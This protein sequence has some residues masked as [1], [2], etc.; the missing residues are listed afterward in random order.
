MN[1]KQTEITLL[2]NEFWWGGCVSDGIHMPFRDKTFQRSLNPNRTQNQAS[3]LL[4]S[5]CGRFVWSD[6]PFNFT[7]EDSILK[8][9]N[10]KGDIHL[11]EGYG[12]LREAYRAAQALYFPPKGGSPEELLFRAPQYNT[13][14][15]L[16]YDQ[17]EDKI[18]EYAQ[19]ILAHGMPPGVLMIDD[20]WQEDY[21]V[22]N[23]HPGRFK[24]PKGMV[25]RLHEMG[26]KV[27]LWTCPF[28]S[29]DSATY[30]ELLQKGLL[31]RNDDGTPAIRP[32][33]NGY[34][35]VLDFTNDQAVSWFYEQNERLVKEYGVDGFKLDAGDPQ[36][37]REGD[38]CSKRVHPNEQAEL[39]ALLGRKYSLNEYRACWKCGGEPLAQRLADKAHSWDTKGL[40][41]LIPNGLAQGLLGYAFT[42]PDMIGGGEYKNFLEN[43]NS[44]DA[45]LFVRYAQCAA[46]FPMMQ[47]SAAPWRVLNAEYFGYCLD[48][49][50]LHMQFAD[51]IME[52]V[53]EAAITGEPIIRYMEYV[54]P[55]QG[56]AEIKDQFMLGDKILVAPVVEKGSYE[57]RVHFPAGQWYG[58]D[59]STVQGPCIM[60]ISVPLCRLPWFRKKN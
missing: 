47:F 24:D 15:E 60:K 27:M 7:F 21:G 9:E 38:M 19:A 33:W 42:C 18:L 14:I 3:P 1:F 29:P 34:S 41:S 43:S 5:S 54:F 4:V 45:E 6:E 37:Y 20:N 28:I 17:Q 23:F 48:A 35:G 32:W 13:W 44:L 49:A 53:R 46:L 58:D 30:R 57:R 22:W 8:I 56:Y 40:A 50:R 31:V 12:T 2:P 51:E 55:G 39:Y 11:G 10:L 16:M 26:F 59:G 36:F 52:L 25:D